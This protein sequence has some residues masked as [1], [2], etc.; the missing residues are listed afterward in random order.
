MTREIDEYLN[1]LSRSHKRRPKFRATVEGVL[2]PFVDDQ[3]FI[4][5]YTEFFD[6]DV[7][8]GKQLDVDGEHINLA[9]NISVPLR[10][11]WFRW[12]DATRGWGLGM[13]KEPFDT[14]SFLDALDDET[15]RRLLRARIAANHWDGTA[16]QAK[17]ILS[18]FFN[19]TDY[20]LIV[21]DRQAMS[22]IYALSGILPS[23]LMLEIF[24]GEY[25]PLKVSGVSTYHLVTTVDG[26]P[27]FGWGIDNDVIGGWGAGTWGNTPRYVIDNV[28]A[29]VELEPPEPTSPFHDP[30][31]LRIFGAFTAPMAFE[32]YEAIDALVTA[33]KVADVWDYLDLLYLLAATDEQASRINWKSPGDFTLSAVNSPVFE[34]DRGWTGNGSSS[35]L[36]TGW[37]P[38]TDA[39]NYAQDD[40]SDWLWNLTEAAVNVVDIGISSPIASMLYSR[41]AAGGVT[42]YINN[43]TVAGGLSG[44]GPATAIGMAGIQ[45]RGALDIRTW[46][47]GA[48]LSINTT[49]ASSGVPSGSMWIGGAN[50]SA[51]SSRQLSFAAWGSSLAGKEAAFHAAILAYMQAV[52]A[53]P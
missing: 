38:S 8:I 16:S 39:V 5:R 31:S 14:G 37:T 34:V 15:Y 35:R 32:R 52:G 48:Q 11:P 3:N 10:D 23:V 51:F 44:F 9:R 53:A 4:E 28:A 49:V 6:L 46:K 45:R 27:I 12:G 2:Q 40:A 20:N 29:P 21:E 13:W 22:V 1:R 19:E 25:L 36:N 30:D 24:G 42:G 50:P 17:E 33:L 41:T 26:E 47:N 18:S 43:T 7:A